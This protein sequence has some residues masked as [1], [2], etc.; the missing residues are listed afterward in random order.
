MINAHPTASRGIRTVLHWRTAVAATAVVAVSLA[1]VLSGSLFSGKATTTSGRFAVA[2]GSPYPLVELLANSTTP[3]PLP[4]SFHTRQEAAIAALPSRAHLAK[5]LDASGVSVGYEGVTFSN[6]DIAN[7]EAT[8]LQSAIEVT[9]NNAFAQGL[10]PSTAI[11]ELE[12]SSY[13]LDQSIALAVFKQGAEQATIDSGHGATLAQAQAY[14]QQQLTAQ[15][16][17]DASPGAPQLPAG[18]TAESITMCAACILGYQQDL[19]LQYET[20]TITATASTQAAQSAAILSWFSGTMSNAPSLS[21]TNVPSA[22]A[23]NL[24]SFLPWAME[25]ANVS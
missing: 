10:N 20:A 6:Q 11:T 5:A 8:C 24:T 15:E 1:L 3:K 12:S 4:A 9:T 7:G 21:I 2:G 19:N 14:A 25:Q 18:E 16:A 22:T 17:F 23:S 13:C